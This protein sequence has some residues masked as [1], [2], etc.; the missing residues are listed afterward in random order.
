MAVGPAVLDHDVPRIGVGEV[1]LGG[2]PAGPCCA[3]IGDPGDVSKCMLW[4]SGEESGWA[5]GSPLMPASISFAS[6][7]AISSML[8]SGSNGQR[9]AG[10]SS[11]READHPPAL[12][13]Q[14]QAE[15]DDVFEREAPAFR[16]LAVEA[17]RAEDPEGERVD[18]TQNFDDSRFAFLRLGD[19]LGKRLDAESDVALLVPGDMAHAFGKARH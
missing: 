13:D 4:I 14:P 5:Q 18:L 1:P 3:G 8:H 12:L 10:I 2:E 6:R 17:R 16:V 9:S 15:G 7:L 11:R 19:D